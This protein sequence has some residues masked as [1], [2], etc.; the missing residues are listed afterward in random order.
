MG[1]T[2]AAHPWNLYEKIFNLP[3]TY[4]DM[5][6]LRIVGIAVL[7][8]F[9]GLAAASFVLPGVKMYDPNDLSLEIRNSPPSAQHVLGTDPFG[10]DL[11]SQLCVGAYY[12]LLHGVV[13]SLIGVPLLAAAAVVL[14]QL[15]EE[16]PQF[17]DT[18]F[19]RYIRFSIFPLVITVI[20]FIFSYV[21][22]SSLSFLLWN[23]TLVL[24][25]L[26]ALLA[27]FAVGNELERRLRKGTLSKRLLLSGAA[28]IFSY[29]TLYDAMMGV[30]GVNFPLNVTWGAIV[31]FCIHF[32]RMLKVYFWQVIPPILCIYIFSRGMLALSYWLYNSGEREK[33]FFREG[34]F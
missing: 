34:W 25:P 7:V 18:L 17:K 31:H 21:R 27:W 8:V 6:K 5:S 26:F 14:A 16:T 24:T 30:M 19:N 20:Y 4:K 12:A 3:H 32:G 15:R 13:W 22:E 23:L 1:I 2:S 10:R 33:Y 9:I 11:F 29:V 28:L